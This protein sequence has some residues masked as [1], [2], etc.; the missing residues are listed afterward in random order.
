M[1]AEWN[2][3][4][5]SVLSEAGM[6]SQNASASKRNIHFRPYVFTEY[7]AIM[8]ANVLNSPTAVEVGVHVVRAFVTN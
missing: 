5:A 6:R 1:L 4:E 3:E 8:A 7:G 2:N